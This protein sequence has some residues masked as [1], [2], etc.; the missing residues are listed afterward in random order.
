[1]ENRL[2]TRTEI[3]SRI[4]EVQSRLI[5]IYKL[6]MQVPEAVNRKELNEL[7]KRLSNLQ[8]ALELSFERHFITEV[9]NYNYAR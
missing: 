2:M 3:E 7:E 5:K 1:M 9:N 4:D 8:N 6:G